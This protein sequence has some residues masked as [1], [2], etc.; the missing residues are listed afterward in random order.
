MKSTDW[1]SNYVPRKNP[2]LRLFC[3]PYAGGGGVIFRDWAKALPEHIDVCPIEPPGRFARRTEPQPQSMEQFI[4]GMERALGNL[5]DL[6]FACFGY[7][8]GGWM[9]LEWARAL[10]RRHGVQPQAMILAASRAPQAPPRAPPISQL[11]RPTFMQQVQMRY[12]AFDPV[13][14]AEPDLLAIVAEI[15][16]NDL[17]LLEGYR[18]QSEEPFACPLTAIGGTEDPGVTAQDLEGWK[19]H[20]SG[21]FTLRQLGG[22]HFFIRSHGRQLLDLLRAAL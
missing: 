19:V 7:S 4:S 11:P 1:I 13:V 22:G 20:T 2:T 17:R 15:M 9:A 10:R 21:P 8:L 18:H 14:M 5:V 6:P 3:F 16:H 12:G